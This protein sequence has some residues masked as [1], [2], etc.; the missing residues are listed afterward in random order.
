MTRPRFFRPILLSYV[1][2]TVTLIVGPIYIIISVKRSLNARRQSDATFPQCNS[3]LTTPLSGD[4]RHSADGPLGFEGNLDVYGFGIRL[5]LYLQWLASTI[6][7]QW[8]IEGRKA[9]AAFVLFQ[10]ALVCAI[11]IMT[12]DHTSCTLDVEIILLYYMYIGGGYCVFTWP[13]VHVERSIWSHRLHVLHGGLTALFVCHM[14]WFWV[15][16][17]DTGYLRLP[18]E[19]IYMGFF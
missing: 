8:F 4:E 16:G 5:S 19:T 9:Q 12:W 17:M 1:F 7:N 13:P 6:T 14:L 2:N 3:R 10:L 11:Y 18:C 15:S